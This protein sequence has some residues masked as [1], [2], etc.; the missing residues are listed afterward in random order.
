MLNLQDNKLARVSTL[1][2]LYFAQGFPWGFMTVALVAFLAKHGITVEQSGELIAMSILPWTFKLL[3]APLIDTINYPAMGRRRPWIL[4]AQ[5]MMAITL[6]TMATSGDLISDLTYLSWMFFLHNCFASLQDVCTDALAVDILNPDERGSVNGFMWSSKIVGIGFGGSIMGTI[7]VSQGLNFT[8]IIQTVLIL[9]VMLFPLFIR[10]RSGEKLLPWTKGET[11]SNDNTQSTMNP[12]DVFR[13]IKKAFSLKTTMVVGIFLLA[14]SIGDGI[15]SAILPILYVQDLGWK[16]ESYSQVV[17]GL[18][19]IFEF[20]GALLG[21][22]L[23]D[24]IGRRK[25][26]SMGYAGAAIMA[27]IFGLGSVYWVSDWFAS[28]Y[29][30]IYPFL[31]AMGTVAMFS[32]CM[33]ISWTKSA[34]TMFTSYMAMSNVST[35]IGNKLA[36]PLTDK[37]SFDLSFIII[38]VLAII[39]TLLMDIIKPSEVNQIK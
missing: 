16:P 10:E 23:A 27:L 20:C 5:L 24:R 17:A 34:A 35:T 19:S 21:G 26:I 11:V 31:R 36:G 9:L 2:A 15:N 39:P 32:L 30:V 3:W 28:G 29:L 7:L 4:F 12:I 6:V 33:H 37:V 8:I 18:G 38:C 25:V 1:C 22:F 13:N 14:A